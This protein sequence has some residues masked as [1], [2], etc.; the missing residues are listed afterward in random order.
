M[1]EKLGDHWSAPLSGRKLSDPAIIGDQKQ[2][3]RINKEYKDLNEIVTTTQAYKMVLSNPE[4]VWCKRIPDPENEGRSPLQKKVHSRMREPSR[5]G[6]KIK[7]L[8]FR[9]QRPWRR[10]RCDSKSGLVQEETNQYFCRRSHRMYTWYFDTKGWKTEVIDANEGSVGGY[11]KVVWGYMEKTSLANSSLN[12]EHTGYSAYLKQRQGPR[13]HIGSYG[14]GIC[15]SLR[16]RDWHP[17]RRF[18]VDTFTQRV[19]PVVKMSTRWKRA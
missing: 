18:K 10:Q 5:A 12:P 15:L 1:I 14:S 9:T 19:V 7:W 17:E 11:N 13:S 3:A 4:Y 16:G 2:F 8:P 6:R